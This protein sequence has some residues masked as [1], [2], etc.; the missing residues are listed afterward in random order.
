M[1]QDVMQV[2]PEAVAKFGDIM[3]VV[4]SKVH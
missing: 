1:A 4:Y 2:K 3:M